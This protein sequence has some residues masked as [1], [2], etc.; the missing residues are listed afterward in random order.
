M[1]STAPFRYPLSRVKVGGKIIRIEHDP[2]DSETWGQYH[3]DSA[4]ITLSDAVK[5]VHDFR[6]T[7]KHELIHA[8]LGISG[9]T[10]LLSDEVEEGIVRALENLLLPALDDFERKMKGKK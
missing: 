9:L 7:V 3:H 1:A 6:M 5:D 8:A 10:H 2:K 4:K